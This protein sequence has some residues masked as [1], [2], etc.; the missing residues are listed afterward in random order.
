MP[1]SRLAYWLRISKIPGIGPRRFQKLM[2]VSENPQEILEFCLHSKELLENEAARNYLKNSNWDDVEADIRWAELPGHTILTLEDAKYPRQLQ[3]IDSPPPILYIQGRLESLLLPQIAIVGSRNPSKSGAELAYQ[4][5]AELA[6]KGWV[7]TSGL[8]YG[9]DAASHQGA[10]SVDGF[11]IGVL[12]CGIENIY[13]KSHKKL[14]EKICEKGAVISE[15][16]P[17]TFAQP[18]LFP[19]RNRIISGFAKGVLVV[20][21]AVKSGSLITARYALEQG[22]EVFAIPGSIHHTLARGCHQLIREGAKLVESTEHILEEFVRYSNP[23]PIIQSSKEANAPS[24]TV[25][26]SQLN[27]NQR[28]ILECIDFAATAPDMIISR[29][30]IDAGIVL[31]ILL[32]LEL[33]GIVTQV[34]GGYSRALFP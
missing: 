33:D 16:P 6:K 9:I 27:E 22:R 34:P 5:A 12:G 13:P 14:A 3:E 17:Q 24:P 28:K 32:E 15:F 1:T 23:S 29:S 8:A 7:I 25:R 10:L 31:A 4:F 19:R 26:F 30:N 21:A 11:T 2:A 18:E 20:E